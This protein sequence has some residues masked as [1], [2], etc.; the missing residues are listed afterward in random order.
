MQLYTCQNFFI[1]QI[2]FIHKIN[3]KSVSYEY[4][5]ICYASN[6]FLTHYI[7]QARYAQ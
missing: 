3:K 6:Y 7:T 4:D 1:L 2:E 5:F